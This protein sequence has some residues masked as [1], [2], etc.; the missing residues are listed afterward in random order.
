MLN[1]KINEHLYPY[2]KREHDSKQLSKNKL[3]CYFY[4]QM[5]TYT[6]EMTVRDIDAI[7]S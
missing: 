5:T 3:F 6:G 7:V 4:Q 2:I 1:A